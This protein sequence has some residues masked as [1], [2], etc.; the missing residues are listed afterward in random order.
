MR[1]IR[2]KISAFGPYVKPIDLDF[3]DGLGGENF[4]LIHGAT[5]SGKTTILDAICYALYGDSSGGGRKG[6]M[7]RSEQAS[8]NDK[9]EVEFTFALHGKTYRIK[10]NPKY[11]RAR[12]RGG[13]LTEEKASAEIFEDGRLLE[14]KDVSEYVENLLGLGKEQFR[15]VVMLPQGAF[16]KFL[17]S[18][19]DD[20]QRV[21]NTL[22][23]AEFFKRV[24]D[25]LKLRAAAAK[26]TFETLTERKS[27]YLE[28]IDCSEEEIPTLIKNLSD[29][30]DAAQAQLKTLEAQALDAQKNYN[31]GENLAKLFNDLEKK[32]R[33]LT[34]AQN[35][36]GKLLNE[37]SNAKAEFDKRTLEETRREE[38]KIL[39]ADLAKKK[40]TLEDFAT[41]QKNLE[42][43]EKS[44][45]ASSK[46]I[47]ELKTLKKKCDETMTT[48]KTEVEKLQDTPAK[49]KDA[50]QKLKDAQ[51]REKLSEEIKTLR[52]KISMAEKNLNAAKKS[53]DTAE[54]NLE[55]LREAQKSGSAARL[56]VTLEEGKPCPVCGAIHHPTP[57]TSTKEIPTDAQIKTVESKLK[58]LLEQKNVVEQNLN[59]LQTEL[60]LKE[61]S[62]TESTETLTAAQAQAE[63]DRL[64]VDKKKLDEYNA[65][66]KRGEIKTRDTEEK[67]SKALDDDK[68]FS[69]LVEN[70]RGAVDNMMREVDAKYLTNKELLD[71]EIF[72]TKKTLDE[73]N[74]AFNRA[75]ENFNRLNARL[76]AQRST[77][78]AAEKNKVEVSAQVEGKTPPDMPA[79]KKIRDDTRTAH[80]AAVEA[81][82]KLSERLDRFKSLAKKIIAL[83]DDLRDADKNYLMWK[84]LSDTANGYV[85]KI[86]FQRYYLATMFKEVIL[87]ANN[88]LEKMSS[89]RYRFQLKEDTSGRERK[90]GLDL[91]IFDEYSGTARPVETLSGGESFL[92]SLSLALGLAAVVQNNSGG[93]R[94]DTIF[95]DE[96]F[97]SLD[98]E[99][100]DFAMRT[101]IELQSG[102]R[103]VG[104]ISHVEELKNQMP[105]RLEVTRGKTGSTAKFIS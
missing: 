64:S 98:S 15:Q 86:S 99:T 50:E 57:A 38:L 87:E 32:S 103:L 26:K 70:L 42:T 63:V 55:V 84:T 95:I 45:L 22:F 35:V 60:K 40:A 37:L 25:E 2:L 75:Q 94:L 12:L 88:R 52:G 23:N 74:A 89:G 36:L 90:A 5:G 49:L 77:V 85:S 105:V 91:E 41:K 81:K 73:L 92:A 24:E 4:F 17:L 83:A 61:K 78:S 18:K 100:L 29:E 9:T 31:D 19:S 39:A 46:R 68:K 3:E 14:A 58:S 1:P 21:L 102:G 20:K 62:L 13:G 76:A 28:E 10:R 6:A 54:K 30:L 101:L 65:R 96:G 7:M 16:Q 69:G 33:A 53:F 66:I 51:A 82:T 47:D 72:S 97:G 71:A 27:N 104:I 34:E 93:I 44:A 48:L 80:T 59:A 8:S 79:L 56:A 11:M 67:L 43:A